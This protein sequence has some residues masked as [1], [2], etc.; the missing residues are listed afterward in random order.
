MK[1]GGSLKRSRKNRAKSQAGEGRAGWGLEWLNRR[2]VAGIAGLAVLGWLVGYLVATRAVFPAPP[3]PGDMFEV[4][5]LRGADV[6]T[7]RERLAGANLE[8]GPIDS[9][10]HPTVPAERVVGQSPLPG[11]SMLPDSPVRVTVSLGPQTR[12]VP[13]VRGLGMEQ[14]IVVLEASGFVVRTDS[15]ESETSR[16]RVIEVSPE[17]DSIVAL[18]AEV[19]V[20]MSTGP[21]SVSMP[22]V[23][24]LEESEA[25]ATLDSLGLVVSEVREVFR[26]GRDQGIVV[27][28]EPAAD[29]ELR[30]GAEVILS[31]GRRG[32]TG[33]NEP[34][35][36]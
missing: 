32:G 14:A 18:P 9:I 16:G 6:S 8:L 3:P 13:D 15:A 1:L 25:I 11:Q 29:T 35:N 26:F 12:A 7:A 33:N 4:P 31:V 21:P 2:T 10:A 23:L 34:P 24:G 36:S 17:P 30:R 22:L 5:D 28:Q 19:E 20:V 27:E